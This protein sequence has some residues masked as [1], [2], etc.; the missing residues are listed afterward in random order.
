M[1]GETKE[2]YLEV[3]QPVPGQNFCCISFISPES[4]IKQKEL[5]YFNKFMNQRCGEL[6]KSLEETLK[7]APEEIKNSL[8]R[9][10]TNKLRLEMK[11]TY[12]EFK[13]KF[14]DFTYKFSGDLQ[15][16]Y[17]KDT[18]FKTNVRGVKVRGVYD[19][20]NEAQI[21]A[22]TLQRMDR[23][24]HVY[25]GQVGYW[26]PWD[27]QADSVQNEEY[28]EEELNTMMKEYKENEIRKDLFYEEQK[29]ESKQD[30]MKK[31]MEADKKQKE[32]KEMKDNLQE[33]DP[34]M[35]SKLPGT[36]EAKLEDVTEEPNVEEP[37]TEP[38]VIEEPK[39][40]E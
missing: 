35:Q 21:R 17:D 30:A 9:E 37:S 1:S 5:Y 22:K 23:S 29:R 38:V 31:K 13:S 20:Y 2:D 36:E 32:E 33:V 34:W 27:P 40:A 16:A 8:K 10:L 11:Y 4:V 25:V 18:D 28:L 26:L 6:E 19:S 3:D 7:K 12:D 39:L 15:A 14:D 24:F